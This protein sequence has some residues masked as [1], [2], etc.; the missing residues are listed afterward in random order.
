M[1]PSCLANL[2]SL[3]ALDLSH[4]HFSGKIGPFQLSNLTSLEVLS[5]SNNDFLIPITF[6]SFSNLS[7]HK[8]LLSD[9]NKIAF[10]S[11]SY[12]W[13]PTFQ[14]RAL[15]LC[16]CS[17]IELDRTTLTFRHYQY[18]LQEIYFSDNFGGQVPLLVVRE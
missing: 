17:L 13:V 18:D 1:L 12:N 14:L 2:T 7:N 5:L 4:N 16:R 10:D 8:V 3:Y 15:S 11:N 9:N 6:S